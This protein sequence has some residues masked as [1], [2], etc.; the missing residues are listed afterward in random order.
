[1]REVVVKVDGEIVQELSVTCPQG[2]CPLVGEW[3]LN[4]GEYAAGSHVV[5]VKATDGVGLTKTEKLNITLNPP[6]PTLTLSGTLTEQARLGSTRPRYVLQAEASPWGQTEGSGAPTFISAFGSTGAEPGQLNGPRG[7]AAD[8][9]GHVWVVDRVNNRVE[10]FTESGEYLGK[11]GSAGTGNGQFSEPWGIA[12]TATGNIWVADTGN[13]RLEEFNSKGEFLQKFGTKATSGSKGTEFVAPEGIATAPGGMLWVSDSAGHRLAEFRELAF[14][15]TEHFV[16]NASGV[17]MSEPISVAVDASGNVYTADQAANHVFEFNSEGSYLQTIGT[18][19]SGDG[20]LS[21]PTGV[22]IAP[23]G[24]IYVVDRG[25]NRVEAF[26]PGGEYVN[27]FG[28]TGTGN[29]NFTEPR[30][31]A[32]GAGSAIFVTDKGNNRVHRWGATAETTPTFISAFGSTG[33]EPGQLNGPRGV[34]AD[35]KGHVWVVDRVNNRVEEFNEAGGYL[36]K[37]GTTGT[38]N[39]QLSEPWGIAV[40]ATGNIWVAD[41]GNKRLEEFNSKGEFIQTFGTKA[42]S[43]SKGTEFVAPEGIAAAPGG[44]L[45]VS[46]AAGHRLAEFR[47]SVFSETERFVRNASGV[48][49]SEPI[50]V[51]VDASGDV[52]T[53]D[54]A[55]N[56]VFEFYPGGSY[57]QTIGTAGSGDG[58]LS[59]PTGVAIAPSGRVYVVDRGNNRVEAFSPKGEYVNKFGTTGTGNGNFTE[60][61]AI[62]YVAGSAIFV[63]DK[64]N[65]R[66][67]RWQTPNAPDE[68]SSVE[69]LIDGKAVTSSSSKCA[70]GSCTVAKQYLLTSLENLGSHKVTVIANSQGGFTKTK[71]VAINEQRDE[72]KPTIQTGGELASAPEGWVQQESYGFTATGSDPS[73]YGDTSLTFKIDGSQVAS[74]T[75][76]CPDGGCVATIS[77]GVSMAAYAGGAHQAEVIATDGAGNTATKHWTIN[78]DPDGHISTQEA[79]DTLEAVEE[80]AASTPLGG[81]PVEV[82]GEAPVSLVATS[83]GF[84]AAGGS[85]P[86][87][88]SSSPGGSL[89]VEVPTSRTLYGCPSE[90]GQTEGACPPTTESAEALLPIQITPLN[91]AEG[92][93][94]S[95]LFEE[96]AAI[97]ANTQTAVDTTIRPLTDGGMV[98]TAIRDQSATE[99]YSYRVT[100]GAEQELRQIDGK[101]VQAFYNTGQPSFLVSAE[102]ATDAVGTEVPTSLELTGNNVVT[103]IVHHQAGNGGTPFVYPVVAGSGWEGGFHTTSVEMDNILPEEELVEGE[104]VAE[105]GEL[106]VSAPEPTSEREAEEAEGDPEHLGGFPVW[107]GPPHKPTRH[108]FRGISCQTRFVVVDP[109]Q[110]KVRPNPGCGNP[111][112]REEGSEEAVYS[113]GVRGHFYDSPGN[114]VSHGGT[115]F[116]AIECAKMTYGDHF[117]GL[118]ENSYYIDEPR[119]C[120]WWPRHGDDGGKFAVPI[121]HITAYGEWKTGVG[122][123]GNWTVKWKGLGMFIWALPG[124]YKVKKRKTT[125]PEC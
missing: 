74:T 10:E 82:E 104:E 118:A 86:T 29:G 81:E 99:R 87:G 54:Q 43:G 27:K 91:T 12:V 56:H 44:M 110:P 40:T 89:T 90:Q 84:A 80:T 71:T 83:S 70:I 68:L 113:Y 85:V 65:N 102:P 28:T 45:W 1:M 21:G 19:G 18:A 105:V 93:T 109:T 33:A 34:A 42:T 88:V 37:F 119:Y 111:F 125:C 15:E 106:F 95:I 24:R 97:S 47:E 3:T 53:A 38:G 62:A 60:P 22:A 107:N 69:V 11:F 50:S 8:G 51:A 76:T 61:R 92:A 41:T 64:G 55:A 59:G 52:Y 39:G 31:I 116:N 112:T 14:S 17:A 122:S 25:N 117:G 120:Q 96:N 79:T 63:T 7:V 9:A 23:S 124:G 4:S 26:G 114:Y 35:G 100:V 115:P 78:V 73:G 123:P 94:S 75:Q 66:V 58:Q 72:T 16:R 49:M 57:L 46:D 6:A 13:K 2:G 67:H 32:F 77:K 5:E 121:H 108:F 30:A 101:H 20:Q 48:A 36:G 98:Y 103:L